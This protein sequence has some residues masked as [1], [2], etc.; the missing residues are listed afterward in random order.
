MLC[1]LQLSFSDDEIAENLQTTINKIKS[2]T[3][4]GV[5]PGILNNC[6]VRL[7]ADGLIV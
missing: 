3:P 2:H 1:S 6:F 7:L 5:P 4:V